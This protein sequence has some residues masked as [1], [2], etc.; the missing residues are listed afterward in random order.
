[1]D[2]CFSILGTPARSG[3]SRRLGEPQAAQVRE[4]EV[5]IDQRL[6]RNLGIEADRG[7]DEQGIQM[8]IPNFFAG[9]SHTVLLDVVADR[10]GPVADVTVR[11]KDVV[12]LKN[13]VA[14]ASL[15][16]DDTR[17]E[18]G[19]LE[20]NVLK[21]LVAVEFAKQTRLASRELARGEFQQARMRIVQLREFVRG[22][23]FAVAG[24]QS[25]PDLAADEDVL[26]AYVAVVSLGYLARLAERALA[27]E[28]TPDPP[29]ITRDPTCARVKTS[30][31][32]NPRLNRL[33]TCFAS[34]AET[35]LFLAGELIEQPRL[36]VE[37]LVLG[38]LCGLG[39][40]LWH[41]ILCCNNRRTS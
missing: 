28:I 5:A 9:D 40:L 27:S 34:A 35:A 20:R 29:K 31:G 33:E 41:G 18:A 36:V 11:Y 38:A 21:N 10:P 39:V 3:D 22:M 6:A 2:G 8:V 17:R 24:W 30:P 13:G 25:D 26:K 1:M 19:P 37:L 23:R 16:L 4:A 15:A 12:N 14:Q 7:D 32:G